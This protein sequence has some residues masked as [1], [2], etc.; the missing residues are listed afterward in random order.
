M[1]HKKE[2]P[3]LEE[4]LY[5]A[6]LPNGLTVHLLPKTGFHKTYGIMTTEYG[7]LITNLYR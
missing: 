2:Y 3:L 1:F 7:R 6:T 5:S 4:T